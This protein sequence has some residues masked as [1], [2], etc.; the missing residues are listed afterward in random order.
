MKYRK[1]IQRPPRY[2]VART[3]CDVCAGGTL[4][5]VQGRQ[6]NDVRIE[7]RCAHCFVERVRPLLESE[8]GVKFRER[9]ADDFGPAYAVDES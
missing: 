4:L 3:T 2:A 5:M 1:L 7:A 9:D 8:L 6:R